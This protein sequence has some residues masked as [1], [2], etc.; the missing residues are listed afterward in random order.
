MA[1]QAEAYA[2]CRRFVLPTDIGNLPEGITERELNDE[3]G[4]FGRIAYTWIARK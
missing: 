3:F 2:A 4:R 1:P